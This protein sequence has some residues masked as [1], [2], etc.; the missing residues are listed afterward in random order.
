MHKKFDNH[1][2]VIDATGNQLNPSYL[3]RAR[4]LVKNGRAQWVNDNTIRII[5]DTGEA[6]KQTFP[7]YLN[8][9]G[10]KP[11]AIKKH[12]HLADKFLGMLGQ[13]P[14]TAEAIGQFVDQVRQ[15]GVNGDGVGQGNG[16]AKAAYQFLDQYAGFSGDESLFAQAFQAHHREAFEAPARAA[17]KGYKEAIVF[18]PEGTIIDPYFLEG[19]TN[20][21]FVSAFLS[22]QQLVYG[23]YE[24]IERTTPFEWG[25][26]GW[27]DVAAYGVWHNRIWGL[28]GV[29]AEL[30]Q[31]ENGMLSIDKKTFYSHNLVKQQN[32]LNSKAKANM[33]IAGLMDMGLHIEGFDDKKADTFQ[34]SCPDT[35]HLITVLKAYF[36]ERRRV[37]CQC[38]RADS[39][40]CTD[41]CDVTIVGH[42]KHFISYRFV[43]AHPTGTHDT[44]ILLMAVTDSAPEELGKIQHYLHQEAIKYGYQIPPWTPFHGGALQHWQYTHNWGS[45][46]WLTVGSGTSWMDFFYTQRLNQWTLNTDLGKLAKKH[47]DQAQ[48]CA[49]RFGAGFNTDDGQLMLQ[50]PSLDDVKAV[51]E[52]YKLANNIRPVS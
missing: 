39:Y 18:I 42:H 44:D 5:N 27:Q 17:I 40:P 9:K 35:P 25:W 7:D 47:P 26:Q 37:C 13:H 36:K 49:N 50:N 20:D 16:A 15:R 46:M 10:A 1:I 2:H 8:A 12:M 4:G 32:Q 45:K 19:L 14:P 31:V 33:T 6:T 48:A 11:P 24:E 51:L 21:E 34:L 22:L 43:E 23:I 52:F 29:F 38:H 30:G 28:L 3:H 41:H